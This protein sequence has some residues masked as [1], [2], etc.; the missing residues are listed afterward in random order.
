MLLLV[1]LPTAL[2]DLELHGWNAPDFSF[3]FT[4][5]AGYASAMQGQSLIARPYVFIDAGLA[6]RHS[7]ASAYDFLH[8][9]HISN[10]R[11]AQESISSFLAYSDMTSYDIDRNDWEVHKSEFPQ[12]PNYAVKFPRLNW[13][14]QKWIIYYYR[15]ILIHSWNFG[16]LWHF[17]H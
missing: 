13:L 7:P 14:W 16:C 6:P 17:K 9:D 12:P 10:A 8:G 2:G 15:K 1:F 4:S 11:N 5:H 3:N